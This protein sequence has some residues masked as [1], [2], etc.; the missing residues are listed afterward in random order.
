VTRPRSVRAHAITTWSPR[1]ALVVALVLF[2]AFGVPHTVAAAGPDPSASPTPSEAPPGDTRSSGE[3]AGF[4]GQ[5]LVAAGL[6]LVVGLAAAGG[7]LL[8][9]RLTRPPGD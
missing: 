9:V 8:Y 6:V 1:L 3:G 2:A 7:T 5:P 4:V